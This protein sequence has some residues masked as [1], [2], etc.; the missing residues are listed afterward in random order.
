M[1]TEA[2]WGFADTPEAGGG[3]KDSPWSVQQGSAACGQPDFWP[4]DWER[5]KAFLSSK[6]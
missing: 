5:R 3:R 4:P 1:M 6:R 2:A